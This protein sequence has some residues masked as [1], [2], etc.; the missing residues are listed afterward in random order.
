MD[1]QIE[2]ILE[3]AS[4]EGY[5]CEVFG[6]VMN[7]LQIEVYKGELES[8]DRSRDE[9]VGI[10]LVKDGRTGFTSSN[11]LSDKGIHA[12]FEEAKINAG[13][14][15]PSEVDLLADMMPLSKP[16]VRDISFFET[17]LTEGKIE[18]V[19][20]M[21]KAALGFDRS[22]ENTE[23]A[24][25]S[26]SFGDVYISSTKG[27]SRKEKRGICSCSVSA[28]AL[29]DREVRT[30][31]YYS[32]AVDIDRLDFRST[33]EE[34]AKRASSLLKAKKIPSK[35]YPAVM[36]AAAFTE[37]I[38]LLQE[39]LSAEMVLKGTTVFAEKMGRPTAPDI[40]TLLD[41]PFLEGGCFNATFDDEGVPKEK[42]VLID[43]GVVKGFLHNVWSSRKMD[44]PSTGNAVRGS[45]KEQPVPG[46]ANLYLAPG[47]KNLEEMIAQ[48]DEG[49]YILNIMGMHTA[50][51][52]S[53]DFSVGI[54]G[55][56][57]KGGKTEFA[58][59]EMTI[60]GNILDLLSGV[61]EIG[62]GLVFI[63]PY[64]AP[65]VLIEGLSISGT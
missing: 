20:Q 28:V 33:G 54:S 11:D 3:L 46:P 25:Y 24:G 39:G 65:P 55:L 52:I 21:E 48:I 59:N 64:G 14:S 44:T 8:I 45:Y 6:E 58:I 15:L 41:D 34:A 18:S 32:Q 27:F 35:R 31:W 10:R 17:D 16:P 13:C 62:S 53:G 49:V 29:K 4:S 30:G 42:Y 56:Y 51:P 26:E 40:F 7:Q 61:R 63:G 60:S 37:I 22:I 5:E 50:D 36:D 1:K 2:T 12:A 19:R 9:G 38:Y 43:S 57:I 23:G 47:K